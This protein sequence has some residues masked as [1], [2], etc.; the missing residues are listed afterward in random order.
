MSPFNEIY[1]LEPFYIHPFVLV[2][3]VILR[4]LFVFLEF[5]LPFFLILG[6]TNF[7]RVPLDHRE[8]RPG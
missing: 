6:K 7:M 1:L 5:F 4:E 3:Q 8:T 2:E